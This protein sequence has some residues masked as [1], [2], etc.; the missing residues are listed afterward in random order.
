MNFEI[1]EYSNNLLSCV[2]GWREIFQLAARQ[3]GSPGKDAHVALVPAHQGPGLPDMEDSNLIS[4]IRNEHSKG[5][6]IAAVC[7]GVSW[8]I[9][10]G[11][12]Q[13]RSVT[14]HWALAYQIGQ[15]DKNANVHSA[16][17]VLDHGDLVTAGGQL[18]WVDL[19]LH[20]IERFWDRETSIRCARS[21]VWEPRR[22][23]QVPYAQP[24]N[25]WIP[26]TADPRLE[27]A[28]AWIM[29]NY[30][31][32]PTLTDWADA[33]GLSQR[34]LER[35]WKNAFDRPIH[36]WLRTARI[37]EARR[38]LETDTMT[39]EEITGYVGYQDSGSFRLAFESE[40]GWTPNRYR[41]AVNTTT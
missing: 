15:L 22:S 24:G 1:L 41:K 26:K 18:A 6:I 28:L 27:K 31:R 2:W 36:A 19:G 8:V 33:S 21:L 11:I 7:A 4:R 40:T 38:L 3:S 10:S 34:T 12:D 23:T 16:S 39:W 17:M 5:T 9:K 13:G 30:R 35:R 37:E 32:G 29:D 20:L 25:C 14:T